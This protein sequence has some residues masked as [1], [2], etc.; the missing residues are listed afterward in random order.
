H[1]GASDIEVAR[2]LVDP[3][4][5]QDRR[6]RYQV[7]AADTQYPYRELAVLG[8]LVRLGAAYAQDGA[9]GFHV[10]G[11]AQGAY[12]LDRPDPRGAVL[13]GLVRGGGSDGHCLLP[14][15]AAGCGP[16]RLRAGS[17]VRTGGWRTC[18]RNGGNSDG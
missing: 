15:A 4:E 6:C 16:T 1:G 11:G 2:E 13:L 8:Q 9:R 14:S 10:G 18:G 12:G 7:P 17:T 5:G 3:E